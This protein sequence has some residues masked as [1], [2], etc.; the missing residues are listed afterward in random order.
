MIVFDCPLCGE[1]YKLPDE[2]GGRKA[3]CKNQKCRQQITIPKPPPPLIPDGAVAPPPAEVDA[4]AMAA[5][6][7]E[8]PK[9]QAPVAQVIE[10]TCKFCDHKWTEPRAK[11]GKNVPCP[12]CRHVQKVPEPKDDQPDDWRQAK[13]KLP[14]LAKQNVEKPDD[15]QDAADTKQVSGESIRKA[16]ALDEEYEPRPLKQKIMFGVMGVGLVG[17]LVF[18]GCYLLNRKT[19][20]DED[21]LIVE[22][23]DTSK[24]AFKELPPF[25]GKLYSAM[26]HA[27]AS[28][29]ALRQNTDKKLK[30]AHDH[31]KDAVAD[32][33]GVQPARGEK[34][35]PPE[36]DAVAAELALL[37]VAFGGTDDEVKSQTRFRWRPDTAA[38]NLGTGQKSHNIHEVLINLLGL[39]ADNPDFEFKIAVARRLTREL[40]R[41]GQA[42]LAADI[43]PLALFKEPERDEATAVIA[44]E[45][46]QAGGADLAR[47]IALKHLKPKLDGE[48]NAK[49]KPQI[50]GV[51]FPASAQTLFAVT[52]IE[53][54]P[55]LLAPPPST[56]D[57]SEPARIAFTGKLLL[58]DKNSDEALKLATRPRDPVHQLKALVVCAEW[59]QDPG[60]AI[61]AAVNVLIAKAATTAKLPQGAILRLSQIAAASGKHAEAQ[62]LADALTDDGLKAW[63]KG[64]A[65]RHRVATNPK[66]KAEE[67][68]VELPATADKLKA[69]HAWG[70]FWIA[71]QNA[72]VSGSWRDEKTAT[73]GWSPAAIHPFALA[74]IALGIKDQ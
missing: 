17:S 6:A 36:R 16:G 35:P 44:L 72:K 65:V 12:E 73:A 74:G 60:S 64:D 55:A 39:L 56:G 19:E 2:Y 69:G 26:L 33:R 53:T 28:E 50:K 45:I 30:E 68:W 66:E 23:L 18:G 41:K 59:S 63:A 27:A 9:E 15:V 70:R 61:D 20:R 7:D 47:E 51:P 43:L 42:A 14:S 8:A 3:K 62:K 67:S 13:T 21:K 54:K 48:L 57:V 29:Y 71:R 11:A 24:E 46:H 34:G 49:P 25:E 38:H 1:P 22:A 32:V 40:A 58:V 5:L 10:M 37:L 4:A 52:G 31:F